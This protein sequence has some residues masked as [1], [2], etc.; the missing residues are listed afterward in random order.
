MTRRKPGRGAPSAEG[1]HTHH[2]DVFQHLQC[3]K[4]NEKLSEQLS[5]LK[6]ENKA[7]HEE[8]ARLLNQ[9]DLCLRYWLSR[10]GC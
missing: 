10:S 8:G 1:T 5:L 4:E 9:K 3:Q 6:E 2:R 7:L